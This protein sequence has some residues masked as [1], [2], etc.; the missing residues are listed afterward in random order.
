LLIIFNNNNN[1]RRIIA[2]AP[3]ATPAVFTIFGG[4]QKFFLATASA[5][6]AR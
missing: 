5:T 1:N 2:A 3:A 4:F 6:S